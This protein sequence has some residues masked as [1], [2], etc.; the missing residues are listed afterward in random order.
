MIL[1]KKDRQRF[2]KNLAISIIVLN[3]A[4]ATMIPLTLFTLIASLCIP[5]VTCLH[6][7]HK[8]LESKTGKY[9]YELHNGSVLESDEKLELMRDG[10]ESYIARK[11]WGEGK[12]LI[13]LVSTV[14]FAA[15][16]M[17]VFIE[18]LEMKK[19]VKR[20]ILKDVRL[21][22]DPENSNWKT[23]AAYG[24]KVHQG[25]GKL[26][27]TDHEN[28]KMSVDEFMQLEDCLVKGEIR[29]KKLEELGI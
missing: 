7:V 14:F 5:P 18:E 9:Y 1:F 11:S 29:D 13:V 8:A 20:A 10:E 6:E 19:A 23:Y 24:K 3:P 4:R 17:S 25:Y 2:W 12:L 26:G 21:V 27:S 22:P 16:I 28:L 15:C